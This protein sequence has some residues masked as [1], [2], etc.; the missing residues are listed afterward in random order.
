MT[1]ISEIYILDESLNLISTID[2]FDNIE[3]NTNFYEADTFS[4]DLEFRIVRD[5]QSLEYAKYKNIYESLASMYEIPSAE[6]DKAHLNVP[7]YKPRYLFTDFSN[8]LNIIESFEIDEL[9]AKLTIKGR[10]YLALLEKRYT[11]EK[12]YKQTSS[13][14]KS[15]GHVI[16]NIINDNKP[17]SFLIADEK[18]NALGVE[19]YTSTD[20]DNNVYEV[21]TDL[22]SAY[23]VGFNTIIDYEKKKVHFNI[24]KKGTVMNTSVSLDDENLT[25]NKYEL[26]TGNHFNYALVMGEEGIN[27]IVDQTG[28]HDALQLVIDSKKKKH[29][30]ISN[31]DYLK[32]L[33]TE[34]IAEL[35]KNKA[36]EHFDIDVT[37]SVD[38]NLGDKVVVKINVGYKEILKEIIVTSINHSFDK[39]TYKRS[40]G[41]GKPF[42]L[43]EE[44]K[45]SLRI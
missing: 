41:F 3:L 5:T 20:I 16:S 27:A 30:D 8:R 34:G 31:K 45:K 10:G 26:D 15:V 1:T 24:I 25:S 29:T 33:E 14:N 44:L 11:I 2:N 42:N 12:E 18:N 37:D 36:E 40:V 38:V 32:F 22:M 17:Q 4:V 39:M 6:D 13:A 21:I 7:V 19:I 28:G 9:G 43:S 23:E 35:A